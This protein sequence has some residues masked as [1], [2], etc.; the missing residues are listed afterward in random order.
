MAGEESLAAKAR[1]MIGKDP[2]KGETDKT[3]EPAAAPRRKVIRPENI[4]GDVEHSQEDNGLSNVTA[5]AH[6][7]DHDTDVVVKKH[8]K[9]MCDDGK[10]IDYGPQ[11]RTMPLSHAKHWFAKAHGVEVVEPK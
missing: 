7:E 9:L 3:D 10:I 1:A 8:F 5:T 4:P 6:D 11:T 2:R